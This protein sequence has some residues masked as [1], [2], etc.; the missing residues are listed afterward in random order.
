M[1]GGCFHRCQMLA[2]FSLSPPQLRASCVQSGS[3]LCRNF[4]YTMPLEDAEA[5]DCFSAFGATC[6]IGVQH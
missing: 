6:F 5:S 3:L 2:C 4:V 1:L